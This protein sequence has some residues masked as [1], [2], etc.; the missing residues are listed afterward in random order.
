MNRFS[1]T[2]R[3]VILLLAAL[4]MWGQSFRRQ[5]RWSG[6][7]F[8]RGGGIQRLGDRR[9][10]RHRSAAPLDHRCERIY[11][12]A[13]LP[14]GYYTVRFEAPGMG[15]AE[16]QRVKVDVG[17]ETR[18]DVTLSVQKPW[19]NP[20]TS[21]RRLLF[22]SRDSSA[23]AE[24]VDTRQVEES[25]AQ[26]PRL[27]EIGIPGAWRRSALPARFARIVHGEWPARKVEYLSDRRR[28]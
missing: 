3:V 13:E 12:A 10:R 7:G 11:V 23:L 5:D 16:R 15:K 19:S 14:V 17:G 22:C 28:R 24:V 27:P 1:Q 25:A 8:Q 21:R 2:V 20:S 9:E 26:R 6:D 18:V 4:T